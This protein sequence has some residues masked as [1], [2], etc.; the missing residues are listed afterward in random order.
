MWALTP[1]VVSVCEL[2]LIHC[3]SCHLTPLASPPAWARLVQPS[4]TLQPIS[5]NASEMHFSS[6]PAAHL[7]R[8]SSTSIFKKGIP[9]RLTSKLVSRPFLCFLLRFSGLQTLY[10]A[11]L[12]FL[13]PLNWCCFC[14]WL[15]VYCVVPCRPHGLFELVTLQCVMLP[16]A[17]HVFQD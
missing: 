12:C 14:A 17:L 8:L 4:H 7:L 6:I 5:G 1:P 9:D 3:P 11:Q 16:Y 10:S 2:K 15:W 13:N